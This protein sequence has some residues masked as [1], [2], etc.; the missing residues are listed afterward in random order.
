MWSF[1]DYKA[2]NAVIYQENGV[3]IRTIPAIHA[4]DGPVSFIVEWND[5]KFSFSSDTYP[6][7]WWLKHTKNSDLAIHECFAPPSI[8]V[9]KQRFAVGD[10]LNVATQVHTSPAM[11]GKVMAE[12]KPRMAVGYHVFNDFDTQPQIMAEIRQTYDGPRGV[13][14]AL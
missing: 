1:F 7:K 9:N 4:L 5:L 14:L 2:V 3:T 6:N 10:A 12:I 8:M 11:F 13:T